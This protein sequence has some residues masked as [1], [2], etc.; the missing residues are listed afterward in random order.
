MGH[1]FL[2]NLHITSVIF[3][4]LY[5]P[6]NVF[7]GGLFG[8]D[9]FPDILHVI[10][11]RKKA[12]FFLGGLFGSHTVS[13]NNHLLMTCFSTFSILYPVFL[14]LNSTALYCQ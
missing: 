10:S 6:E 11:S 4:M 7:L 14:A 9:Y 3:C 8:S 5:L 2:S 12:I 1:Y 13:P